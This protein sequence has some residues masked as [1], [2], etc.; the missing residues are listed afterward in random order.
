MRVAC[1]A[2]STA[3]DIPDRVLG[4]GARKLRCARCG[5]EWTSPASPAETA[6]TGPSPIAP[7]AEAAAPL[8]QYQEPT[9]TEPPPL[10]TPSAD[11]PT[12]PAVSEPSIVRDRSR[13][14]WRPQVPEAPPPADPGAE[15]RPGTPA[16]VWLAWAGTIVVIAILV[17]GGYTFRAEVMHA[18]PASERLY[19]F[20]GLGAAPTPAPQ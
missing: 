15:R 11:I 19:A 1:P 7:R 16:S 8:P 10:P 2:C 6:P 5:T 13:R 4:T 20:L 17:W 9:E 12:P 14:T 18:W 3:Y